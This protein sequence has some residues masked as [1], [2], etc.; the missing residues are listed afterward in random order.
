MT[1]DSNSGKSRILERYTNDIFSEQQL[2]TIGVEFTSKFVI[3]KDG[4]VAKLQL[5]DTAGSEQYRS[6]TTKYY[7][8]AH[9]V[10]LC[11]D[12]TNLKSFKNMKV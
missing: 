9:A 10:L 11:Y 1:G 3:L 2:I 5:W 12:I 4:K 7:R 6:I 8:G